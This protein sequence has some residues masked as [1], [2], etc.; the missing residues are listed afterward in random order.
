MLFR[1][2]GLSVVRFI[3]QL[4]RANYGV[5]Q[6]RPEMRK[7]LFHLQHDVSFLEAQKKLFSFVFVRDPFQRIASAYYD[8]MSRNWNKP[9]YDLRWMRDE[10]IKR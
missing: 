6:W 8:K 2:K 1:L 10:I 7:S 5:S 3:F 4:R 9:A